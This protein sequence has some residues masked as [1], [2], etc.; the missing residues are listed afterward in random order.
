[1]PAKFMINR[2]A[3]KHLKCSRFLVIKGNANQNNSEIPFI[4]VRM[5]KIK[6]SNDNMFW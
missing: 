2:I 5:A 3:E 1:L 6:N 4:L